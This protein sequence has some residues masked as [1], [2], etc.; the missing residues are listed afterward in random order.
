MTTNGPD[1]LF[2]VLNNL[3]STLSLPVV[4]KHL[5]LMVKICMA[6]FVVE[7]AFL[8]PMCGLVL[9]IAI[10]RVLLARTNLYSIFLYLPRPMVLA[11]ATKEIKLVSSH[12]GSRLRLRIGLALGS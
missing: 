8:I 5:A 2:A 6:L 4:M 12:L 9:Y 11:L 1:L 10:K 3:V 7:G